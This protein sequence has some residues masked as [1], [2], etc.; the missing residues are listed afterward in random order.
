MELAADNLKTGSTD[1]PYEKPVDADSVDMDLDLLKSVSNVFVKQQQLG[2]FPGGQLVVRRFG[3]VVLSINCGLARGWQRRGGYREAVCENTP[4]A[5]FSA[6]KPAAAMII[7]LLESLGLLDPST[8]L[9]HFFP[10]LKRNGRQHLSLLDVLQHRAGLHLPNILQTPEILNDANALWHLLIQTPPRYRNG[11]LAYL[12]VEY[13]IIIDRLLKVMFG[14]NCASFLES[15]FTQPLGLPNFRYGLGPHRLQ[16]IAWNYW[17]G[18][19]HYRINGMDI[20][21]QFETLFN[22]GYLFSSTNP[23]M[24]MC[25][26]AANLAA[27]YE[28][29]VNGGTSNSG[30]RIIDPAMIARYTRRQTAGWDRTIN[31]YLALGRGF[32]VGTRFPSLY[33]WHNNESCFGHAGM[34]SSFAYADHNSGLAA[35]IVSNGHKSKWDFFRRI[36]ALTYRLQYACRH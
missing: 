12:P 21:E 13:G 32:Y 3:K 16:N 15:E 17:L 9:S 19:K 22:A 27:F 33:D 26:D 34:F 20:G 11:S 6:G 8:P 5:V 31:T 23:S 25:T 24:S 18:S 35:A 14:K 29:L 30:H 4:F 28:F 1:F 36:T 2:A 10:E 7:A